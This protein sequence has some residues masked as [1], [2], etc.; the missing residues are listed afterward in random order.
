[1][2]RECEELKRGITTIDQD[3]TSRG[4]TETAEMIQGKLK[5]FASQMWVALH[6]IVI[7]LS[8]ILG[9]CS[10]EVKTAMDSK[11]TE[12]QSQT[13]NN[14]TLSGRI[15]DYE[16]SL[17]KKKQEL[18]DKSALEIRKANA[19]AKVLNLASSLGVTCSPFVPRRSQDWRFHVF[20]GTGWEIKSSSNST[21]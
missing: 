16:M 19:Q 6:W 10:K 17:A 18:A 8:S 9:S 2:H 14:Q 3:L 11:R 13:R 12:E 20:L 15:H 1:M 5:T 21:H 4:S 7:S